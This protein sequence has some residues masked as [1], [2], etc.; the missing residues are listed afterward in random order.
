MTRE[1]GIQ[2]LKSHML[3]KLPS[4]TKKFTGQTII[5]TGS[6]VGMG[7]EAARHFV[8]LDA[9]KVILAVRSLAKG[10][11]AA[12]SIAASTKREGIA[13]VWE[14]DL[15][16][17]Q[18]IEAFAKRAQALPRLDIIVA[19]AGVLMYKFELAEDNETHITVN[20][21]SHLLL[22]LLLLPKLRE[23]AVATEKP[24]VITFTGSFTHKMTEFVERKNE[25]IFAELNNKDTARMKERYY[26]SK[27]VQLLTVREFAN[28]LAKSTKGGKIITNVVNPGFV[29]TDIMRHSTWAFQLWYRPLRWIM[30]R[31]AEEGGR[32][33]VHGAEGA[34][35]THG[36][37]LDDC[38]IGA[39]SAFVIS[40]EGDET[41]KRLWRELRAKLEAVHSGVLQNI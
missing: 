5:V 23:T 18:S 20:V 12:K 27:M 26:V 17:Y 1:E 40:P 39:T 3:V 7:M 2:H 8:R 35:E 36:Q 13:E 24:S 22:T 31:S 16:S 38:K 6:N 19:N 14:L 29:A 32:T 28:E 30:A 34:E 11:A 21:V 25:N 37:Y 10:E 15:A 4:P 41:Q 33:L 9:A